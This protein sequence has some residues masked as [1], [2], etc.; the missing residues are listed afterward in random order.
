MR[1]RRKF[2]KLTKFTYPYGTEN[3]L[4]KFL[5]KGYT[6]DEHGNFYLKIGDKPTTMFTCHLDTACGKQEKVNHV[7]HPNGNYVGTD[8][9]TILGADDKAGMVIILSLIEKQVPGLYYFF[10]GEEVGCIGSGALSHTWL[11]T[12]F[13]KYITKC[14]SFDRR[15]TT[16]V[17]TEQLY[18]RCAS[19]EFATELS[20][21]LNNVGDFKFAPDDTGVLTDSINFMDFVPECTNI[22]VG[23]YNEHGGDEIQDLVFLKKLSKAVCEIDWETLPIKRDPISDYLGEDDDEF[24]YEEDGKFSSEFYSYFKIGK[25]D[26]KKMYIS[27]KQIEDEIVEINNWLNMSGAYPG[28]TEVI[29]N[30]NKLRVRINDV[31]ESVGDR[32]DL[33]ELMPELGSVAKSQLSDSI[34]KYR[35][36]VM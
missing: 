10:I 1:T 4:K 32:I 11:S 30:G 33:I 35:S 9:K 20:L 28:F 22:S 29:W 3:Q 27:I 31:V 15:G 14:V 21:R 13:S 17:I 23:Y 25:A 18:G 24:E 16:S 8:G 7:F 34:K 2:I 6:E 5:P 19:D 12:E 26:V 36:I